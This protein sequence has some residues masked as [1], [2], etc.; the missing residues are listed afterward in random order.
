[1]FRLARWID[2]LL[3]LFGAAILVYM[4]V[5]CDGRPPD[6]GRD[7]YEPNDTAATARALSPDPTTGGW[8][9]HAAT[10][11]GSDTAD[12]YAVFYAAPRG[13]WVYEVTY[14]A[15]APLTI[16]VYHADGTRSASLLL[17]PGGPHPQSVRA[18]LPAVDADTHSLDVALTVTQGGT[19]QYDLIVHFLPLDL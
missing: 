14:T 15:T 19:V 9:A 1:M 4:L 11:G 10:L 8:Y 7:A 12:H 6:P 18:V 16:T 2:T 5:G 3:A 13:N 17:T